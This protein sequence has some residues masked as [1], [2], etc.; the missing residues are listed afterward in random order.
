MEICKAI[1]K[2]FNYNVL[3]NGRS[4]GFDDYDELDKQLQNVFIDSSED[5][6]VKK[7]LEYVVLSQ[8]GSH[9]KDEFANIV[10]DFLN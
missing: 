8:T 5:E 6:I 9:E 3:K 2:V 4:Y 10:D 1:P 7:V